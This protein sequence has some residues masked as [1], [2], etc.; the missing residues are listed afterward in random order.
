MYRVVGM[1]YPLKSIRVSTLPTFNYLNHYLNF[2][3]SSI[4]CMAFHLLKKKINEKII[5]N[6]KLEN[7][8]ILIYKIEKSSQVE[9]ESEAFYS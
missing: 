4:P 6:K 2:F 3:K 5:K 1:G 8:G 9:F 7:S